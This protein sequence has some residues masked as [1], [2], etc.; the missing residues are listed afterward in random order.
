MRAAVVGLGVVVVA[1]PLLPVV[2]M[3]MTMVP[4]VTAALVMVVVVLLLTG[5]VMLLPQ[6]LLRLVMFVVYWGYAFGVLLLQKC[7]VISPKKRLSTPWQFCYCTLVG[8]ALIWGVPLAVWSL[9]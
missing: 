7:N 3:V 4:S 8:L 9:L 2:V 5:R 1:V 6:L